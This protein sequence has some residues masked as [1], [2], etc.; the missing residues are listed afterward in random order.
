MSFPPYYR[1]LTIL[2]YG[3][4]TS[5]KFFTPVPLEWEGPPPNKNIYWQDD[6]SEGIV[7]PFSCLSD[8]FSHYTSVVK[9]RKEWDEKPLCAVIPVDFKLRKR[10]I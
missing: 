4:G 9:L 8:A 2:E 3:P 10:I 1:F 7:G 5:L 6:K